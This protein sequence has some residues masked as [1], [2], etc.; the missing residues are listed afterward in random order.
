[1]KKNP[2]NILKLVLSKKDPP[3]NV[4]SEK[5]PKITQKCVGWK[6]PNPPPPKKT[7]HTHTKFSDLTSDS[8]TTQITCLHQQRTLHCNCWLMIF[9]F[10]TS[11]VIVKH[12][13]EMSLYYQSYKFKQWFGASGF[14]LGN[15]SILQTVHF[16]P[17]RL[18]VLSK[19]SVVNFKLNACHDDLP[20]FGNAIMLA[21]ILRTVIK[22]KKYFRQKENYSK[23]YC[24]EFAWDLKLQ[25]LIW[26]LLSLIHHTFNL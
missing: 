11:P 25:Y 2:K 20:S 6:R 17:S 19:P 7:K 1:M 22:K 8:S 12:L 26:I 23:L 16:I 18:L 3:K 4:L 21:T 15:Y 5:E 24:T 14:A 13:Q 9:F 10:L